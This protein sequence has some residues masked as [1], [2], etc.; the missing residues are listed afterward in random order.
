[1]T[2]QPSGGAASSC[3]PYGGG[4]PVARVVELRITEYVTPDSQQQ[5]APAAL[6]R[7]YDPLLDSPLAAGTR[8]QYAGQPEPRPR[9]RL[10]RWLR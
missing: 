5:A 3:G 7:G 2:E 10:L 9:R 1:M 8:L 6:P 4:Q